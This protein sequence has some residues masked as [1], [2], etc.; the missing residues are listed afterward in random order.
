MTTY[1]KT[2]SV[3]PEKS[4]QEIEE[5]LRR[6]GA[7]AFGYAVDD[8]QR[9]AAIQFRLQSRLMR[10]DVRLPDKADPAFQVKAANQY[11]Q[12]GR[13]SQA[14][15]DQAMRQRWRALLLFVKAAL[16]AVENQALTL[17]QA[18]LSAVVAPNGQTLAEVYEGQIK[19]AV[20][21]GRTPPLL[22]G[23]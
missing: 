8:V 13:F 19:Q 17:D 23:S 6:Y 21:E 16:E 10:L 3:A 1:A 20:L 5:A 14:A 9:R 12:K 4:R 7:D 2:T 18:L 11:S 22:P 15:Y